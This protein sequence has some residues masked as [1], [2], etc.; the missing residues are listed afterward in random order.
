MRAAALLSPT[1]P[2]AP[3]ALHG[4]FT[5]G[6]DPG[7]GS[8]ILPDYTTVDCSVLKMCL[9]LGSGLKAS[10]G[11]QVTMLRFGQ[12]SLLTAAVPSAGPQNPAGPSQANK[13]VRKGKHACVSR[14][15]WPYPGSTQATSAAPDSLR[16]GAGAHYSIA[17]CH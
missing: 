9:A 4:D 10:S 13:E 6:A 2:P 5:S 11:A 16:A 3:D 12:T 14:R 15:A 17:Y 1:P 8:P 7:S